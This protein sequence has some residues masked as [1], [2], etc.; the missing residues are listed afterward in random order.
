MLFL[1][2]SA[3]AQTPHVVQEPDRVL[4]KKNTP[5]EFGDVEIESGRAKP[6]DSWIPVKRQA[7]FP[8]LIQ[9][10]GSFA[11]ELQKSVDSL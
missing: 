2:G 11:P 10:R 9:I 1:A 8:N 4:Y 3:L 7:V 6:A 5:I